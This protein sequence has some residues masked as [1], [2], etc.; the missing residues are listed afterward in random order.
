MQV[1]VKARHTTL[2][3]ALR[4]YALDKLGSS[5][6]KIFDRPAAK[7]EIELSELGNKDGQDKECRIMVFMPK[8]PTV[9]ITE[10]DDDMYKAIDLAQD[11]LL[12]QIKRA[13]G[14]RKDVK[15]SRRAAQNERLEIMRRSLT[16]EST[17][18][19][20]EQELATYERS[21]NVG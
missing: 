6:A 10:T 15:R 9:C 1:V 13:R 12:Q 18:A 21:R 7:L 2:T 17:P 14:R 8:G 19:N 4:E 11:R 5:L 3:P 20:W 16:V